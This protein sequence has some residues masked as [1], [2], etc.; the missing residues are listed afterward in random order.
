ME[1]PPA[2]EA[3]APVAAAVFPCTLGSF[4][5]FMA[6]VTMPGEETEVVVQQQAPPPDKTEAEQY[7][8]EPAEDMS[9]DPLAY[10]GATEHRF[11]KLA[12]WAAQH[13]GCPASSASCERAFSLAGRL[14]G[15]L[16]QR[17]SEG[18]LEERMWAK[19][20]R[21]KRQKPTPAPYNGEYIP[22]HAVVK[23]ELAD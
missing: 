8:E 1:K 7:L 3:S 13:L 22:R 19:T 18:L 4:T 5:D 10:W 20:N 23:A 2:D 16:S 6:A 11:P 15:D 12:R 17:M 14:F 21:G 9:M